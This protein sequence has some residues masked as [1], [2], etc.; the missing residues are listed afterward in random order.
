MEQGI[1]FSL[2][3]GVLRFSFGL[4]NDESDV[5]Q[6]LDA[7]REWGARPGAPRLVPSA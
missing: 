7:V 1:V 4:Y 5:Q 3:S 2:R 6:V